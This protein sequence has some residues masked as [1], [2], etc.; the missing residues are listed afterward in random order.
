MSPVRSLAEVLPFLCPSPSISFQ[1]GI[2]ALWAA[3]SE[4]MRNAVVS[5][6]LEANSDREMLGLC[7]E[8]LQSQTPVTLVSR[9]V[10]SEDGPPP[11]AESS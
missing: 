7:S 9:E 10:S 11:L 3:R 6:N 1:S 2:C 4:E 5:K 8:M